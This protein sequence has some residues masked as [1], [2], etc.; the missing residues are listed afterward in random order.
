MLG[1]FTS[2]KLSTTF[3]TRK[4]RNGSMKPLRIVSNLTDIQEHNGVSLSATLRC[5][6][7]GEVFEVSHTGK[8]TK[9]LFAPLILP[10]GG[11][12]CVMA[13]CPACGEAVCLYDSRT[14]GRHPQEADHVSATPFAMKQRSEWRIDIRLNYFPEQLRTDAGEY[15]NN[16]EN[17]FADIRPS[18]PDTKTYTLLEI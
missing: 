16:F 7:G 17:L 18:A 9:G 4:E 11:Q 12:L 3:K 14:D 1:I 13:R 5:V 15:S 8:Q 10:R 2:R 6:C